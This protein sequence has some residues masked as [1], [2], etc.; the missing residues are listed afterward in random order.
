VLRIRAV[1][2]WLT[3]IFFIALVI[4]GC[5][6]FDQ[7]QK[8]G[9]KSITPE[10]LHS[11]NGWW[12]ARFRM[13]WPPD[14]NPAWYTDLLIAHQ[15][16]MPLLDEYKSNIPLWRFHRRAARDDHGRQFSFIFYSSSET[17]Q[18][19]F[20]TLQ[21]DPLLRN[22]KFAGVIDED[23]YD[24]PAVIGKPHIEDTSDKKWPDSIQKTWP[25]YIMGVSQMWLNL[26]AE[27]AADKMAGHPPSSLQEIEEFY[28]RVNETVTELWEKEGRHA[29]MHHLNA[30]FGYEP[31]IYWEKRFMTF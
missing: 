3:V 21:S 10:A 30:I 6:S 27:V 18:Q 29:F 20:D 11:G 7:G 22:L 4:T 24:N 28:Q 12:Y 16:M 31:L 8:H 23:V 13:N 9:I 15:V 17:A 25:Y 1:R 2:K 19:I 14:T 5:A 26:I